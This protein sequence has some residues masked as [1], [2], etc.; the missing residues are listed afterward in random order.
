MNKNLTNQEQAKGQTKAH[1][2]TNEDHY[3]E[4][5]DEKQRLWKEEDERER[6]QQQKQRREEHWKEVRALIKLEKS[7]YMKSRRL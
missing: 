1:V 5:E 6:R 4:Q 2:Y 7:G 3:Y